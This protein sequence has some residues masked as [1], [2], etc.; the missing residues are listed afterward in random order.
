MNHQN[1]P[2]RVMLFYPPGAFYQRGE[3]RSQGNVE[4]STATTMRAAN[5]LGYAAAVL[6]RE[7]FQ[8]FLRDYQTS[9]R[10]LADLLADFERF[11]PH[12]VFLSITNATIFRDLELAAELKR[13]RPGLMIMLKGAIFFNPAQALLDQLDLAH[14]DY[15]IGLESEFVVGRLAR[16]HFEDQAAL[17]SLRGILYKKDGAW[18]PT[19]FDSFETDL[20]ALPFPDRSLMENHLYVRPDTGEPQATIATSRGCPSRCTFCVT[21]AISGA[22]LRL[23][24]PENILAELRECYH[25]HGIRDFFFKS[26]TFTFDQKWTQAVCRAILD[27]DLAGK[28]R[29][30]ANSKVKPLT[31]E[32]LQAMKAAGCWL[33]AF[34]YESGHPETLERI[35]KGTTVD[36]NL[37]ATRWARETGLRTFGFF[38]AGLPWEGPE[39]LEATRRHIFELDNDFLELHIAVPYPGTELHAEAVACG[40]IEDSVLGKDYFNAPTTGTVQLSM[41]E[42]EAFRKKVLL[43]FHLR[44]SYIWRKLRQAGADRRVLANYARF[45]L[46]LLGN[47][48]RPRPKARAKAGCVL[49]LGANSDIG[50]ALARRF[51]QEEGSDLILASRD[52]AALEAKARELR[53][54]FGVRVWTVPFDAQDTASHKAFYRSLPAR[55]DGVILTFGLLESPDPLALLDVNLLGAAS[56]LETVARDL[57]ERRE[58]FILGVSS[59]AGERGRK[60]NYAYGAAKAGLT[61]YLSGLRHRLFASGVHVM[62]VIPGFVDTKMTAHLS[63]PRALTATP[64]RVAEHVHGAW[65]K[66]RDV[67]FTP[68][69]WRPIMW[70]IR[71][72]PESLFK[73]TNL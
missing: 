21:P 55:P 28:I 43:K 60:S 1:T 62:T 17:P 35:R 56:I 70:L 31:P 7:G 61:A 26:D 37:K 58:G 71:N 27:S 29:W 5:D 33:V 54:A 11:D 2:R 53:D 72:L 69:V 46:R 10:S 57:E 18:T 48:L 14:A 32:T 34:G 4:N 45:G 19:F 38:L 24:S 23:R 63:M 20:D 13:R 30:V 6:K 25:Q 36:D 8:V 39:H 44:P 41:A 68:P 42:I 22:K 64:E 12:A 3:D 51:A 59:V 49:V 40:L 15:L 52:T 65:R 16:A 50:M 73:R 66:R 9:R 47:T 67:V